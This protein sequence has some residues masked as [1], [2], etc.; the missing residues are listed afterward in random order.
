ML[1]GLRLDLTRERLK[2][3]TTWM[4]EQTFA[5]VRISRLNT[6]TLAIFPYSP[7][8]LSSA[9]AVEA[10]RHGRTRERPATRKRSAAA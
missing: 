3:Q 1:F 9:R 10:L 5:R 2:A 4:S 7:V 6:F 8:E